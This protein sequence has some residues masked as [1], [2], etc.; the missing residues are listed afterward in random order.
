MKPKPFLSLTILIVATLIFLHLTSATSI[1]FISSES[2]RSMKNP[3][4]Y[5]YFLA[6]KDK[7]DVEIIEDSEVALNSSL[8]RE[9]ASGSNVFFL[10]G[11][12]PET[13]T[14]NKTK[15]LGNLS[16]MAEN[17]TQRA[18]IAIGNACKL[19]SDYFS[20]VTNTTI[21]VK[22]PH[23]LLD[24]FNETYTFPE[25]SEFF[26]LSDSNYTQTLN[27]CKQKQASVC[28]PILTVKTDPEGSLGFDEY[29]V[30]IVEES[31]SERRVMLGVNTSLSCESCLG[32]DFLYRLID[33]ASNFSD[34]GFKISSDKSSYYLGEIIKVFIDSKV[35]IQ[36]IEGWIKSSANTTEVLSFSGNS[37]HKVSEFPLFISDE[38][39]LYNV[40]VE[41]NGLAKHH[42]ILVKNFDINITILALSENA[43][44]VT[45]FPHRS[46]DPMEDVKNCSVTI[47]DPVG[48]TS[49]LEVEKHANRFYA[50]YNVT[51]SG[52]YR[53]VVKVFDQKGRFEVE[54]TNFTF[55]LPSNISIEPDNFTFE[56]H[57]P[58]N[59]TSIWI[60]VSNIGNTNITNI[61]L[62]PF[63]DIGDWIS[64]NET[65][66]GSLPS[67][68]TFRT[69]FN[70]SLP[71]DLEEGVYEG[72]IKVVYGFSSKEIPIK[73]TLKFLGRC[74][75]D[76]YAIEFSIPIKSKFSKEIR[77]KNTGKGTLHIHNISLTPEISSFIQIKE[78]PSFLSPNQS[79]NL[80]L[81]AYVEY[82]ANN[83][84]S[85][86][87]SGYLEIS[88]DSNNVSIPVS[89][90]VYNDLFSL[91]KQLSIRLEDMKDRIKS[92]SKE[93]DVSALLEKVSYINKKIEDVKLLYTQRRL[94]EAEN[95]YNEAKTKMD[96][97]YIEVMTIEKSI[98]TRKKK[99]TTLIVGTLFLFV[100]VGVIAFIY[101]K[102]IKPMQEYGW[103]YK[104]WK[105]K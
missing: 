32:W 104:K 15:F 18:V 100:V 59:L 73:I 8:W 55:Y 75:V 2:S 78:R 71:P 101:L 58:M 27:E 47:Y 90:T 85:E 95:A 42:T 86:R 3:I 102:E 13:L 4:T 37:T 81:E 79:K 21:H 62:E 39:G 69:Y 17:K 105:R 64:I 9:K 23:H 82:L 76:T 57:S 50:V 20:K 70:V 54:E 5:E 96:E 98:E 19:F 49:K 89:L 29:V 63:G 30:G 91:S 52:M 6:L 34:M 1:L 24:G 65:V 93:T 40:T 80:V 14:T 38:P 60:N 25:G 83:V 74:E 44:N 99:A 97:L 16:S 88:T 56:L 35:P 26:I 33:W 7:Y 72:G 46:Q 77:I 66:I 51:Y 68:S 22:N 28:W 53:V 87:Y 103:L 11:L 94:A 92:L 12:S 67:N 61:T 41:V 48:N 31:V 45:V 36:T 43:V 84:T 10:I